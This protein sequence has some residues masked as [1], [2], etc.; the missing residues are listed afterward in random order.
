MGT[1]GNISGEKLYS[2]NAGKNQIKSPHK[3]RDSAILHFIFYKQ[4]IF[5]Y[6]QSNY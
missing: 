4:L 1:V 3:G 6:K 5:F 2:I